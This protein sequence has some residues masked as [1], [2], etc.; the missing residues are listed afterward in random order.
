MVSSHCS[1]VTHVFFD[2]VGTLIRVRGG[3]IGEIYSRHAAELGIFA[4]PEEIQCA[5][6]AAF[7]AKEPMAFGGEPEERV[8]QL[9]RN[10][11]R[12]I[13][14]QTFARIS[15]RPPSAPINASLL[16]QLF[17][18]LYEVFRTAQ[19][20]RLEEG[21][22]ELLGQLKSRGKSLGV[23]SNFDSRLP[24]VLEDLGI[25]KFFSTIVVSSRAPAAKPDPAIFHSALRQAG[26][27]NSRTYH[28]GDDFEDDFLGAQTAG[29]FALLYDPKNRHAGGKRIGSLTEALDFL[30]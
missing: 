18:R 25:L 22:E 21:C 12:E 5:F 9:E 14:G 20:W 15:P 24:E 13:V 27:Q 19:G 30:L 1:G 29:I 26:A 3:S 17:E 28:I 11:W 2:A 16:G 7:L 6:G 8:I 23:I 4:P 10:W